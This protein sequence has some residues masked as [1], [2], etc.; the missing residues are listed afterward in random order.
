MAAQR[1][2]A[3]V[4][5]SASRRSRGSRAASWAVPAESDAEAP[6]PFPRLERIHGR[7]SDFISTPAGT[8]VH[9]EFFTHLFYGVPE[10]TRF[11]VRQD[12]LERL[13]VLTVGSADA[14]CMAPLLEKIRAQVGPDV[15][16]VWQAVDEIPLTK[17]GKHRYTV[18]T[19]P[20]RAGAS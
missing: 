17:T 14:A 19:L 20:F 5:I 9:G 12:A 13:D 6:C 2:A 1:S 8:A 7:T 18:S 10:V 11:Q 3:S 4:E 16:V 15:D